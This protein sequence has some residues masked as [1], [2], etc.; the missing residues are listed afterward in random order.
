M[1]RARA[2]G[3]AGGSAAAR[4]R[5]RLPV[6]DVHFR[7]L[8]RICGGKSRRSTRGRHCPPRA[9]PSHPSQPTPTPLPVTMTTIPRGDPREDADFRCDL[10]VDHPRHDVSCISCYQGHD[11]RPEDV[12]LVRGWRLAAV[13]FVTAGTR[14]LA[15]PPAAPVQPAG[16][17]AG[18]RPQ[19]GRRVLREAGPARHRREEVPRVDV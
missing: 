15:R 14:R 16:H 9:T 8:A 19:A 11:G 6:H 1:R 13:A 12:H 5:R 10:A 4:L 7:G 18:A 3:Q 2:C 17:A